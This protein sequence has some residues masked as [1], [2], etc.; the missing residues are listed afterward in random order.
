MTIKK[1]YDYGLKLEVDAILRYRKPSSLSYNQKIETAIIQGFSKTGNLY[2]CETWPTSKEDEKK[3]ADLERKFL[4]R[5]FTPKKNNQIEEYEIRSNNEIKILL[6]EKDIIQ[7]FK[8]RKMRWL[9]HEWR[10]NDITRDALNWKPEGKRPLGRP[11]KR[12]ELTNLIR[13]SE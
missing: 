3:L 6:E 1:K 12:W 13:T 2:A 9:G 7:T 8:G 10:S 5:I 4:R 11:E